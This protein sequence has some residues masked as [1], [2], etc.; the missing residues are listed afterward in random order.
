MNQQRTN[1]KIISAFFIA[2]ANAIANKINYLHL[3]L[4]L[5]YFQ[6]L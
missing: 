3:N 4:I 1:Q 5:K 6:Y 2:F